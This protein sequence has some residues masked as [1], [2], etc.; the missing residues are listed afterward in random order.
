MRPTVEQ[1]LRRNLIFVAGKGGVGKSV[2][3]RA[4]GQALAR[5]PRAPRTLLATFEDPTLPRNERIPLRENL[6]FLN[7]EA[8]HAFEEYAGLKIGNS[9]LTRLFVQNALMRYIA[10]AAPGLHELVLLGKVW[11]ESKSTDHVVVDLPAT[12]HGLAMFHATRNFA[13]LFGAGG[14]LRR[15]ADAMIEMFGDPK[16]CGFIIAALPEEMPL[17]E[18]IELD[19]L[20]RALFP[21]NPAAFLANRILPTPE[22]AS[23]E[24][25]PAAE[26]RVIAETLGEFARRR[27]ALEAAN[28]ALWD[29]AGLPYERLPYFE[30]SAQ[31]EAPVV[32]RVTREFAARLA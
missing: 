17:R 10:E 21:D 30:P 1:V 11:H 16:R 25:P 31:G 8:G 22:V 26:G 2:I 32:E 18:A 14:P 7:I 9:A 20:L 12:G 15:D 27:N 19:E 24:A 6:D 4:A 13:R 23:A 28:L 3:A 5:S 29:E